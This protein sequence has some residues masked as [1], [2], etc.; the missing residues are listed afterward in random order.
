M[1]GEE[2]FNKNDKRKN[3]I[4]HILGILGSNFSQNVFP[5][6]ALNPSK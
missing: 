2:F 1:I 6:L 4:F 3:T 5:S